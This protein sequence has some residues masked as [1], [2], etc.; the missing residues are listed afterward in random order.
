[1]LNGFSGNGIFYAIYMQ[2]SFRI[3][4]LCIIVTYVNYD[5]VVCTDFSLRKQIRVSPLPYVTNTLIAS[6]YLITSN[7]L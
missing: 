4:Y 3:L 2:Y 6:T 5:I 1:M 7:V